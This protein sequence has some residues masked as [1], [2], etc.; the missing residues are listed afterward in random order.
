MEELKKTIFDYLDSLGVCE[1]GIATLDTL[2]GG[3]PSADF[4]YVMPDAKSAISFAVSF[5]HSL[6]PP[7]LA[8]Q[9]RISHEKDNLQTNS[10]ATGIATRLSDYLNQHG[11]VSVPVPANDV[12][13]ADTPM[14][15]YDLQPPIAQRYLAIRSGVGW[16]GLSGNIITK[17]AGAGVIL[18]SVLTE[19]ELTPTDPLPPDENYCDRCGMCV[20]S[21]ASG[22]IEPKEDVQ[23]TLGG[24]TFS[25]TKRRDYNRCGFIC[26]GFSGLHPSK[27]WSTWSPG[28]FDIPENDEEIMDATIKAV[29]KHEKWPEIEGGFYHYLSPSKLW[30]MCGNCQLVC[31]PDREERKQR[32]KILVNS[33]V[34]VQDTDGSLNSVQPE[35]AK[36]RFASMRP[37][38]RELY[39]DILGPWKK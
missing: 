6:I 16:F 10:I 26:G 36:E 35:E 21:C 24:I 2:D 23:V 12:Y 18:A 5:D 15:P 11:Y 34:V 37:E 19:A 38:I 39:E 1:K 29:E 27:K 20:A 8:K 17:S 31:V 9:D 28:R 4:R 33:G 32:Y 3:P 13:R 25:Y 14:A 7:F 30:L 22:F